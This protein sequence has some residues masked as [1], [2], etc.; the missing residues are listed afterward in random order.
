M[1]DKRII[2]I[3]GVKI[4]IDMRTAKRVDTIRVGSRVKVLKK[5]YNDYIV[6]HGIVI[7]FEEFVSLPTIVVAY[8]EKTYNSS[9]IKFVYFNKQSK[10]VEIVVATDDDF[11]VDIND[12]VASFDRQI[13][14]KE[15][16]IRDL[17]EKKQYFIKQFQTVFSPVDFQQ[18]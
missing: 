3:E 4:E 5:G 10:D 2:E 15:N 12:V 7:G 16:E 14:A 6:H 18:E 8:L 13:R 17:E 1:S 9:D 11:D